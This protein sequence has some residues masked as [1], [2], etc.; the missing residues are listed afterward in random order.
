L[1]PPLKSCI[2]LYQEEWQKML[3]KKSLTAWIQ[4]FIYS[5]LIFCLGGIVPL[6]HFDGFLPGH[7]HGSYPYHLIILG[8]I[9]H[10]SWTFPTRSGLLA[11][12]TNLE[13]VSRFAIDSAFIVAQQHL[14]PGLVQF[15]ASGLN[16]GYLLTKTHIPLFND[17][18]S[19][20]S[21]LLTILTGHSVLL[22]PPEKPPQ[23]TFSVTTQ[24][25]S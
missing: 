10:D 13:W 15:F 17:T 8:E 16:N 21:V 12:Q 14:A 9:P 20:D 2:I 19:L 11:Q 3:L 18:P 7:E 1:T 22:P 25:S 4:K 24:A 6:T 5:W 23:V